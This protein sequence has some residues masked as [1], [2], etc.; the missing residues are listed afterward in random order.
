MAS[1]PPFALTKAS[2]RVQMAKKTGG[3]AEG[4]SDRSAAASAG[5]KKRLAIASHSSSGRIL[6][7]SIPTS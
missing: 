2:L 1:P 5:E 4:G 7:T 3:R 6:S